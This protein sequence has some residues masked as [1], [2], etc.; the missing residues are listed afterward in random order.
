VALVSSKLGKYNFASYGYTPSNSTAART[1]VLLSMWTVSHARYE[2]ARQT[3]AL[4][5]IDL[6][7]GEN[8]CFKDRNTAALAS[9]ASE[10]A[11]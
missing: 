7:F 9:E 5:S 3:G 2:A 11:F 1:T 6:C 8:L 10:R 4:G